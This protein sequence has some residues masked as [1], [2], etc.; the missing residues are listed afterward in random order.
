VITELSKQQIHYLAKL[1]MKK[2]RLSEKKVIIEGRRSLE[3]LAQWGVYAEELYVVAPE[4]ALKATTVFAASKEALW[5]ICDSEHPAAIA[6]LFPLPESR[7][8]DFR[9]AFYLD[10]ISD[11]GNLDTIFRIAAAFNI[12]CIILSPQCCEVSSPKV[13][14]A[15]LGAVYHVPFRV[16]TPEE[17]KG[18][19]AEIVFLDMNG[20]TKL[21][22]FVPGEKPT[23]VAFGSEAHGLSPELKAIAGNS[24]QIEMKGEMESL[25]AAICAGIVAYQMSN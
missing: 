6:G 22:D 16:S 9:L 10:G 12:N 21:Q 7:E 11:P 2:Y 19:G 13:I 17:L 25:N 3:Q 15:S 1:R 24:L 14:R 18:E 23:I 5:R 4:A 20:R 8:I